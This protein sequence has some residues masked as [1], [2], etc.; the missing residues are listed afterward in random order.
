MVGSPCKAYSL[1]PVPRFCLNPMS[2]TIDGT[3]DG[4]VVSMPSHVPQIVF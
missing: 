3:V 1:H 2:V 4:T